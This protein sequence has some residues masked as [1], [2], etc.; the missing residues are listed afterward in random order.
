MSITFDPKQ[1]GNPTAPYAANVGSAWA[2]FLLGNVNS[3]SV[4]TPIALYGRRKALSLYASDDYKVTSKLVLNL[5]LRWDFNNPYK[6]KYGHWSDFDPTLVNPVNGAQG[7]LRFL[8]NG[9]QSFET[10]QYWFNFAPHVGA[11]YQVTPKTVVR[12][13]FAIFYV[14]LN[15]NTWGAIPYT[16]DPGYAYSNMIPAVSQRPAAFNWDNGYPGTPVAVGKNPSYTQWGMVE[17]DPHALMPGNTQQWSVGVQR[18]LTRSMKV[19]VSFIGS[20]SYHLQSG[21]LAGNQPKPAVFQALVASGKM[22]NWVSDPA[23]AA[24]AGVPYPYKGFANSA[25]LA[26]APYPQVATTW[27]PLFVVGDP[28]GNSDYKALQINV[29]KRASHGLSLQGSYVL[30]ATHG[31]VMD[32][33]FEEPWWTGM[34]QNIYDLQHERNSPTAFDTTHVIKGYAIYDLPFGRG[35]ALGS[36]MN[37]ALDTVVGGWTLN[38]GYHYSSGTPVAVHSSNWYLNGVEFNSVYINVKPGCNLTT[39]V[40]KLNQ[41]YLNTSCFSNPANGQLGNGSDFLSGVRYPWLLTEDL[42]VH[43]N[44]IFGPSERFRLTVRGEF[45][46]VLNRTQLNNLITNIADPNFGKFLGRG[47]IGPRIGQVGL[48]LTF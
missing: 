26:I 36:D 10:K 33:A 9:S 34:V 17:I 28:L 27:G 6:E 20:H 1:T 5:D 42:G 25:V 40:E 46:N 22:W 16:F 7:A 24:A 44:F 31:D 4:G 15:L 41:L 45:F 29:T 35:K 47:G 14:P 2:S 3:A 21:F 43:K 39:G 30:S 32:S 37:R 11:A 23:S 12:A 8:S 48:R 19:D 13:S 38:F 18:E